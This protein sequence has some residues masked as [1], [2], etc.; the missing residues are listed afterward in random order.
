MTQPVITEAQVAEILARRK[1]VHQVI[2]NNTRSGDRYR[3]V[4]GEPSEQRIT[5]GL[6]FVDSPNSPIPLQLRARLEKR[7]PGAPRTWPGLGLIWNHCRI[8]GINYC[9]RHDCLLNGVSNGHVKGW[10]EKIWRN[11]DQDK[12]IEDI[13][14]GIRKTDLMAMIR[15]C[16]KRWNIELPNE[17]LEMGE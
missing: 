16:C 11:A 10:H 9:L 14:K 2:E 17:Q 13:N 8:R 4:S 5:F 12:Y 15:F 7:M 1:R 6:R 3:R